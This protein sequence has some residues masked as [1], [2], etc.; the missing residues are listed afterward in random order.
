MCKLI[1]FI[2]DISSHQMIVLR[3]DGVSRHLRFKRPGTNAYY[4]D[5]V[6]WPGYLAMTGDMGTWTFSRV[7]DMFQFFTSEHFGKRDSF[8]INPGYWSEK[9]ESGA[10]RSRHDAPCMEFSQEEFDKGL[11]AWLDAFL[12]ECEDD[13]ERETATETIGD[14]KGEHFRDGN[15]AYH[16]V[17]A[18]DWPDGVSTYDVMEGIGNC[19]EYTHHY[20]WACYAIVWGIERYNSTK[21]AVQAM[22]TFF[23]FTSVRD[24]ING[25]VHA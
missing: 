20:L 8:M 19:Q 11:Q 23:A 15:E 17:D 22:D 14:L 10:G 12:E 16:A 24:A 13:D 6:T 2:R 1:R 7:N 25:G 5:L 4:F 21:I 9:F 3:D 18:A